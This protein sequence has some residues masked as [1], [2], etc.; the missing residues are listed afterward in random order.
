MGRSLRGVGSANDARMTQSS[1]VI[2]KG[3]LLAWRPLMMALF[4]RLI[5]IV[6]DNLLLAY[7]LASIGWHVYPSVYDCFYTPMCLFT[8][9]AY[10]IYHYGR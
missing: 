8:G 9:T 7:L 6:L 1:S 2:A 5:D 4:P 10:A 3:T